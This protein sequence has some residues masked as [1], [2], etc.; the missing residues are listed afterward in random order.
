MLMFVKLNAGIADA[1]F[2]RYAHRQNRRVR[3]GIWRLRTSAAGHAPRAIVEAASSVRCG[4]S[5]HFVL[6]IAI[7][8]PRRVR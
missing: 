4:I 7:A 6:G 1:S 3:V 8:P 2:D 5:R